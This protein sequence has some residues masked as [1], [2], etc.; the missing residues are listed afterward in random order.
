MFFIWYDVPEFQGTRLAAAGLLLLLVGLASLALTYLLQFCFL[1][2][3][4]VRHAL[5]ASSRPGFCLDHP[6]QHTPPPHTN[7]P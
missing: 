2:R 6:R 7:T 1:V 3:L 5:F 4:Y